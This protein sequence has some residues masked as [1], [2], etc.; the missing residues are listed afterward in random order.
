MPAS[1]S[2]LDETLSAGCDGRPEKGVEAT[3]CAP[4]QSRLPWAPLTHG[5]ARLAKALDLR[6][7]KKGIP[8]VPGCRASSCCTPITGHGPRSY[9]GR[10]AC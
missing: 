3:A 8:D 6:E 1:D 7:Q 9:E 10:A 2:V 4:W 5:R